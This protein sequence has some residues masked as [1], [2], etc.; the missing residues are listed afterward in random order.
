MSLSKLGYNEPMTNV[1]SNSSQKAFPTMKN[2][3]NKQIEPT[4]K[5]IKDI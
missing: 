1:S 2:L 5:H 3:T 4:L